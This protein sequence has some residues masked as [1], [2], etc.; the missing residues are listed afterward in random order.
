[1]EYPLAAISNISYAYTGAI[2]LLEIANIQVSSLQDKVVEFAQKQ[3]QKYEGIKNVVDRVLVE[4]STLFDLGIL[5]NGNHFK[6]ATEKIGSRE[7]KRIRFKKNVI[8]T[9]I[10][11]YYNNDK[12]KRIDENA[13]WSYCQNHKRFRGTHSTRLGEENKSSYAMDFDITGMEEFAEFGTVIKP[14]SY[15][16]LVDGIER[17]MA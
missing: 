16:D 15:D 1:M 6:I 8:I 2:L 14:M 10:N 4:I 11:K 17:N 12:K 7:E 13:F 3:V 9:A 5:E